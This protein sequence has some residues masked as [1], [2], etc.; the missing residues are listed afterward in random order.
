MS[1]FFYGSSSES[2]EEED[3]YARQDELS[4]S[5][6]DSEVE[7]EESDESDESEES[8][9]S[10]EDGKTGA[11]RFLVGSDDESGDSDDEDRGHIVKSAKDKRLEDLESTAKS[12]ENALKIQDWTVVSTGKSSLATVYVKST[13]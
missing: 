6:E 4:E 13:Y 1:R 12:I 7:S 8:D 11:N 5:E 3:I 2:D 9:A 10:S